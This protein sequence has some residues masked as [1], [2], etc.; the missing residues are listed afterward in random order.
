ML[1]HENFSVRT[2]AGRALPAL[3]ALGLAVSLASALSGDTTA[4]RV[5][6]QVDFV[7]NGA[8]IVDA[9]GLFGPLSVAI[10]TSVTPNR[11]YVADSFNNR[12]LGWADVTAFTNGYPADLLIGQPDFMSSACNN[13]GVSAKSLCF[14]AGVAVDSAGNLYVADQTNSRVLEYNTP[15]ATD[16]TA[17]LVFGQGGSFTSNDCNH[18]GVSADSLCF[19]GGIAVDSAG[20]LYITDSSNSRVLEYNT[21]LATDTTADL[22]FGQG[23]SFI[24]N[25]CNH[26]GVSADSLCFPGDAAV[27]S[28]GDVYITDSS[29]SRVLRYN[30]PLT[31][32]TTADLVLGQADL[33]SS[34]CNGAS[35]NSLCDPVGAVVDGAGNLYV[36]DPGSSRVLEYN[37]PFGTG[38]TADLVF[39][40]GGSFTSNDCNHGGV[41]ADSLCSPGGVAVD[42]AGNLY[43]AD[44]IN[45]R[46]LRYN[47]PLTT[48]TTAD[49]VL[50]QVDFVHNGANIVDAQGLFGPLSVAIDTSVT[51]N[52]LYV[53]DSSNS[54]VLG[55]AD[56]TAF[57]NGYRADLLIGQPDFLSSTCNN[58]GVSAKSLCFPTGVAVDSAGNLYVTDEGNSRVLEYNTPFITDTTA[59]LVFGQGGSFTS[60]DCNHGGVSADSLCFPWGVA[61]DSAG[62]LYITD[63]SNSRVLEYNTPLATDTTA[64]LVFGQG[65]SFLSSICNNRGVHTT[66]LCGPTGVAVDRA[67]NLYVADQGNSRVLEY[68]TPFTSDTAPSLVFG[69]AGSFTSNDCNHGGLSADSLCFPPGVAADSAGNLY[70]ADQGNS[71]VLEYHT[72]FS[73][74]TTAD[75]VFGQ[76]G[77]FTANDCN[78][79]GVSA[80]SLCAPG[81]VAVD[82][83]GNLYVADQGNNRAL[84]YD[85]P[86]AAPT[87]SPSP[88]PATIPTPTPTPTSTPTP[89]PTQTPTPTPTETT[90]PAPTST[91]TPTPTPTQTP[92]PTATPT[93]TPTPTPTQTPT[94]TP[95][96]TPT[97]TLT[98]SATATSTS[99]QMP[100]AT[101]TQTP[102]PTQTD[103][104]TPAATETATTTA[105]DTP[106]P[107]P[108]PA[109]PQNKQDCM[110]GGWRQFGFRNQGQCINFVREAGSQEEAPAPRSRV[111]D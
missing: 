108:T 19:P 71:R 74:G 52:R 30:T 92:T 85:A 7:H 87:A 83:A 111:G 6:G 66:T 61:V 47:T 27:D 22:V 70:V 35:A 65:G 59:D 18:G 99:A 3:F 58:G 53:A 72:P 50:G 45:D 107:A 28:A 11:L 41:S 2:L 13:G 15:F 100:T 21:P 12:V 105:T 40:Q 55:W 98:A 78:H 54:R 39:G 109:M 89:T 103:T 5:L 104:P 29:N 62:D 86:L 75:L 63:S 79:G 101:S 93:E 82:S 49:R 33:V 8:N 88:T 90:T 91:E 23:G 46:A 106:M 84:E 10:D 36:T 76:G 94:P 51:P 56:V 60:N 69:Q 77:S 44:Q 102:T 24:S 37:A 43:V 95:T 34:A 32:D 80:D 25:D 96:A 31:T 1:K 81:G 9:Q 42:S 110:H 20:D 48:D 97:Q 57:N 38:A 14:P 73:T 67:G 64:D 4:D 26:G 68:N 16:T 17:D